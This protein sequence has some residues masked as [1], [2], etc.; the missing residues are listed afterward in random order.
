MSVQWY[1]VFEDALQHHPIIRV[2]D[3]VRAYVRRD[4]TRAE[5]HAARRAA[6]TWAKRGSGSVVHVPHR[7]ANVLLLVRDDV[8]IEQHKTAIDQAVSG[9]ARVVST[10]AAP[11]SERRALT[12]ISQHVTA[13][14]K[15]A[16]L[17]DASKID[18]PSAMVIAHEL[19][20]ALQDLGRLRDR[21]VRRSTHG[22]LTI[23]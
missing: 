18:R 21:L 16:R 1:S 8:D 6:N 7:G 3:A 20:L 5:M 9:Q 17:V 13:A 14:G 15:A 11:R 12:T 4:P 19:D 2:S 22:R 10:R 23:E